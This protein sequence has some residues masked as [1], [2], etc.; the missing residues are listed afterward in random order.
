MK[1]ARRTDY[2]AVKLAWSTG[3][4]A[5][6]SPERLE[7]TTQRPTLDAARATFVRIPAAEADLGTDERLPS[8]CDIGWHRSPAAAQRRNHSHTSDTR[9]GER[10]ETCCG[11][12][13]K[14]ATGSHALQV[15]AQK[16][17]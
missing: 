4:S 15:E 3:R 5:S 12:K 7:P 2:H 14:R 13:T 16:A 17:G 11:I 10:L 6:R 9:R 8:D 1:L